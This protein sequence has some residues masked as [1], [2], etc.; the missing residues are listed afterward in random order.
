MTTPSLRQSAVSVLLAFSAF[1]ATAAISGINAGGITSAQIFLDDTLSANSS[2]A[3]GTTQYATNQASWVGNPLGLVFPSLPVTGDSAT[4]AFRA[5]SWS[6]NQP[7]TPY[8]FDLQNLTVSQNPT[9]TGLVEAK[10]VFRIQYQLDALGLNAASLFVPQYVVSG[11]VQNGGF[12]LAQGQVDFI[13]AFNGLLETMHYQYLN[14]TPGAFTNQ[15][16]VGLA[17]NNVGA[18]NLPGGDT[19]TVDGYFLA[20]V[21]PATITIS[22]LSPVPDAPS[23]AL[24]LSGLLAL[25][26]FSRRRGVAARAQVRMR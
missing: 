2:S 5:F 19:L 23:A 12:A 13:S 21:D 16:L 26:L 25:G 1:S 9:G 3:F 7:A 10:I 6:F 4:F 22:M 8:G 14:V 18:F 20:R 17:L 15:P 24:C 11:T